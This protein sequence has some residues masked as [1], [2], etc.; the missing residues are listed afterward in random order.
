MLFFNL[1]WYMTLVLYKIISI[2]K[3]LYAIVYYYDVYD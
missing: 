2:K 3:I 1:L